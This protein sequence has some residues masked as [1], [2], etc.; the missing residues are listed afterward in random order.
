ME[1]FIGK[2]LDGRYL[3]QSKLGFGGMSEVYKGVDTQE[4][5][6][7]AVK[8]L[9]EE[10]MSN[11]DLVRRFKNESKAISVL[12]H[13]NIVKVYDVNV[14][15]KLQYIVMELIEGITLKDYM[16]YRKQ[17][18]SPKETVH[19]IAQ[20]LMALQHAHDKGIVHRDVK[21]HNIMLLPNGTIKVM[22]FGIARF[23]RS[24][25][26]TMTDKAIGSVHYISPEQ[27]KGETTDSKSDLYSVGV[28]MYEMLSGRLPFESDSPVGVAL[29]Q[30]SDTPVPLAQ[31]CPTVP[32]GLVQIVEH[33]MAKEPRERY[34]SA[35]S[36]LADLAAFKR[37]PQTT[38]NYQHVGDTAPTRYMDKVVNKTAA[39]RTPT[40][41]RRPA[42]GRSTRPAA[43]RSRTGS[44]KRGGI[45][46]NTKYALPILA[47]VSVAVGII[48]LISCLL[49]FNNSGM[50]KVAE[51]VELRNFTGMNL[52]QVDGNPEYRDFTFN[53]EYE[54]SKDYEVGY[55]ISQTPKTPKTVKVGAQV[56]LRVSSGII[57]VPMPDISGM[58]RDTAVAAI[59]EAGLYPQIRPEESKEI[60]AGTVIRARLMGS[61]VDLSPGDVLDSG[62][63]VQVYI[64]TEWRDNEVL[65]PNL[66]GLASIE[67]V[68]TLLDSRQL[69]IGTVTSEDSQLP[70]GSV[71]RQSPEY[72]EGQ[73]TKIVIGTT[74]DL[75]LSA[76]HTHTYAEV[77]RKD[78]SYTEA[79]FV[80]FTCSVC[81]DSYT[82]EIPIQGHTHAPGQVVERNIDAATGAGTI[83]Y[84]C[85]IC[86]QNYSVT[87]AAH[88]HDF[89]TGTCPTCGLT[90]TPPP[91]DPPDSSSTPDTDP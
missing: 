48:S 27:A 55:I 79:G 62:T 89:T 19:F 13:P 86:A 34:Q 66:V 2:K 57:K 88:T 21:P 53:V 11:E 83:T 25:N 74:I 47:G 36:M 20:I 22:D 30:I 67:E 32:E 42:Q 14:T 1:N 29:K 75:V 73:E 85:S 31:L 68:Q 10:C 84:R 43:S 81:G 40:P 54:T 38:F 41:S 78:A 23:S 52:S 17:P 18:L 16:E 12:N 9:R 58:D 60:P 44:T 80:R 28:M 46:L 8:V 63:T 76:G 71:I 37:N 64:S 49:I 90:G 77:E 50:F 26:Q 35:G 6:A 61:D 59:K 56:T 33:A 7:V 45:R 82:E 4:K 15:D 3:I 51:D 91:P 72:V 70:A 5:R 39:G 65:L 24:E 69:V 87:I